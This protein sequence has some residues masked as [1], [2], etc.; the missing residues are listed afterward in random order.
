ML[1]VI[2]PPFAGHNADYM[3]LAAA[4]GL[5]AYDLRSRIKG[6]GWGVVRAIADQGQAEALAARLTAEGFRACVLDSAVANDPGRPFVML[7]AIELQDD[8][9]V[10]HLSERAIPIPYRALL[11]IVRGEVQLGGPRA[12]SARSSSATFRAVVPSANEIQVFRERLAAGDI[13]AFAAA[14]LHFVTVAWAARIDPRHF[15]FSILPEVTES[16]AQN[17]DSLVALL[18]ERAQVRVDRSHRASSLA[19]YVRDQERS[20]SPVPGQPVSAD[21]RFSAY[22]RLVAQAERATARSRSGSFPAPG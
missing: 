19:S 13:D 1:V 5:A 16:P 4:T 22:S 8:S 2:G 12:S 20:A 10:L 18:A 9:M 21:D 17:L 6:E 7:R 15:D 11:T 3:R 14:D